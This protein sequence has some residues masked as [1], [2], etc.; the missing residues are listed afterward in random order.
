MNIASVML[1][2]RSMNPIARSRPDPIQYPETARTCAV[3]SGQKGGAATAV[4]GA[5]IASAAALGFYLGIIAFTGH[6][7]ALFLDHCTEA[8]ETYSIAS[9][10][11]RMVLRGTSPTAVTWKPAT[12]P[13]KALTAPILVLPV[14]ALPSPVKGSI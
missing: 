4:A 1:S 6:H 2:R 11:S 8:T 13:P 12:L 3:G 7:N 9:T 5:M 10:T 14:S